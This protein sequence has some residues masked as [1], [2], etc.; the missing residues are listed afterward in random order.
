MGK[1][2]RENIAPM[3]F[4]GLIALMTILFIPHRKMWK[5]VRENIAL[6][7]FGGLIVLMTIL[8][9]SH[10]L[11][12]FGLSY[13]EYGMLLGALFVLGIMSFLLKEN[14][15]YRLLEHAVIGMALGIGMFQMWYDNIRKSLV[16]ENV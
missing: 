8:F 3:I 12:G 13:Y 9:I 5:L 15:F 4:G 16:A 11:G 6:T 14:S 1:L 7:V 2:I 10:A